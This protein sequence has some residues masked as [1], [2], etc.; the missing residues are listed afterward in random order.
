MVQP[1]QKKQTASPIRSAIQYSNQKTHYQKSQLIC[2]FIASFLISCQNWPQKYSK[3]PFTTKKEKPQVQSETQTSLSKGI[4]LYK[5]GQFESAQ[6]YFKT[7]ATSNTNSQAQALFFLA[8]TLLKLKK[9]NQALKTLTKISYANGVTSYWILKSLQLQWKILQSQKSEDINKKLYIQSQIIEYSSSVKNKQQARKI[10]SSLIQNLTSAQMNS[11]IRNSDFL[12][13]RDL[14]LFNKAKQ[15][16]KNKKFQQALTRFRELLNYT[17]DNSPLEETIHQYIQALTSRTKVNKNI[18]GAIL[19]LSGPHKK[20]G[21]RCLNGM[22]LGLGLYDSDPSNFKLAIADS[23]GNSALAREAI[24][25]LFLEYQAIGIIGGVV[26]QTALQLTKEAQNFMIPVILLSQK[27][28][29]TQ[30]GSYSFQNAINSKHIIQTLV[31][32]L[33]DQFQHEKFAILYPNDPFGIEYANL[34]WDHVLQKNKEITGV[35]TYKPGET[36]FN[37]NIKRLTGTYYLED[38]DKEYRMLLKQLLSKEPTF[39][40]NNKIKNLLPP[41]SDFSVLFIPDSVK[42]LN[43]IAP[44]M[45]FHNIEKVT[46]VGPSLWNSPQLLK[47]NKKNKEGA[48]FAD[49]WITHNKKFQQSSFFNTFNATFG[50]NPGLFELLSYEAALAFREVIESGSRSREQLRENL[51]KITQLSSPIG[52]IQISQNREFIHPITVFSVKD[53]QIVH[54]ED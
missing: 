18:I 14:L 20:I 35:Q 26:S 8:E 16:V 37:D 4:Q 21:I 6:K 34:F 23:K 15:L 40:K 19:P 30:A 43:L 50:Y 47:Q 13:I 46:L 41:I 5:K 45:S 44:Y 29:L 17:T 27:S 54:L 25:N 32:T 7:V 2:L 38:R 11:L 33:V 10:A 53:G 12:S 1:I 3:P 9:S 52:T 51:S 24:K 39:V 42:S 31:D 36:D 28:G 22:Q 48:L 49:A